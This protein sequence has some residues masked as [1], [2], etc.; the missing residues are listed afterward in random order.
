MA[1]YLLI[2][3]IVGIFGFTFLWKNEEPTGVC[4]GGFFACL[5]LWW[6]VLYCLLMWWVM[7]LFTYI[8]KSVDKWRGI[9]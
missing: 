9:R 4:V 8:F 3:F 2:G 6:F 5:F 1:I 7:D